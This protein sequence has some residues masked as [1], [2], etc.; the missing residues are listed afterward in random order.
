M[1]K[2]QIQNAAKLDGYKHV[3]LSAGAAS[4]VA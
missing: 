1:V 4:Y 2:L 3:Q